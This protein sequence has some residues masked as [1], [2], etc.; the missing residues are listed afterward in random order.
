VT[1]P[2]ANRA[3]IT[4]DQRRASV[5]KQRIAGAP[6]PPFGEP[7]HH[8]ECEP[9]ADERDVHGERKRLHLRRLEQVLLINTD[10][11]SLTDDDRG[12]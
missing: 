12:C 7:D 9:E 8:R 4:L 2:T 11:G 5:R 3:N 6:T 10:E 1:T